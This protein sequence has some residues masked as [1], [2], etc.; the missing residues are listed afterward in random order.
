MLSS[1]YF[2]DDDEECCGL[3]RC[4]SREANRHG[5]EEIMKMTHDSSKIRHH[6]CVL[7]MNSLTAHLD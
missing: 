5:W 3:F 6:Y 2:T 7:V 4:G 1:C